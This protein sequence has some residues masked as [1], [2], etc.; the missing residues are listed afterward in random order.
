[1]QNCTS[2]IKT[3]TIGYLEKHLTMKHKAKDVRNYN[4]T[5]KDQLFLDANIWLYLYGPQK[6]GYYLERVYSNV[7]KRIKNAKSKYILM[8]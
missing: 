8:S 3:D 2:K 5:G 1:M 4:F 7:F 6:P